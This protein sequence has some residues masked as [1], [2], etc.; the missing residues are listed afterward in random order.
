[1]QGATASI[2]ALREKIDCHFFL[3]PSKV[4]GQALKHIRGTWEGFAPSLSLPPLTLLHLIVHSVKQKVDNS[5]TK[6]SSLVNLWFP[7]SYKWWHKAIE[8]I[9]LAGTSGHQLVLTQIKDDFKLRS[10]F[11]IISGSSEP[12]PAKYFAV[13]T[14]MGI[15]NLFALPVPKFSCLPCAFF[16]LISNWNF[17]TCNLCSLPLIIFFYSSEKNLAS[18]QTLQ[19]VLVNRK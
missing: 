13:Y 16:P 3:F 4:Q 2:T 15:H 1:M 6:L 14:R 19:P 5:L 18:L 10:M 9:S 8:C 17:V 7:A 11:Y 12:C